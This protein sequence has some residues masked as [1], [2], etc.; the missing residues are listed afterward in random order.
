MKRVFFSILALALCANSFAQINIHSLNNT[1]Q[2]TRAGWQAADSWVTSLNRE[3]ATRFMGLQLPEEARDLFYS[4]TP[5]TDSSRPS[6]IDWRNKDGVNYVSPIINQAYCGSCVAFASVATLETQLNIT[7]KTPAS[8]YA[9]SP[10]HLFSCGG[11]GCKSGWTLFAAGQYL[12]ESGVP[13]EACF[14]Y[15]SGATGEDYACSASCSNSSS[16]VM[17]VDSYSTPTFF[18]PDAGALKKALQKGPVMV[19]MVVYEDFL[20]YKS[21]VYKH[22]TGKQLGGHAVSLVGYD[23]ASSAWIVRNSWGDEWGENGFFRIAYNDASNLGM[24]SV[25]MEVSNGDGHIVLKNVT[26]NMAVKGKWNVEFES[27]FAN[28]QSIEWVLAQ[29]DNPV[30]YGDL[31]QNGRVSIDTTKY[32]DGAYLFT[33]TVKHSRGEASTQPRRVYILN[34]K[35]TGDVKIG[36]VTQGQTLT[37]ETEFKIEISASP[38]PLTRIIYHAKNVKTGEEIIRSTYNPVEKM[39]MFWRAQYAPNGDY[40]ITLEGKV[41]DLVSI[42]SQPIRVTVSHP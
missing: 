2:K 30:A 11:G 23:D 26:E 22:T 6:G 38:V 17:K 32:A 31:F 5:D 33:A 9:F 35:F 16:R 20:F 10:Q 15:K 40:D 21:G 29:N 34:G 14:P 8:S 13:D 39:V 27:T 37:A 4:R 12:Q 1:L 42:K 18:F 7:R 3:E 25:A 36:N 24:Q 28:T 41:G 19:A